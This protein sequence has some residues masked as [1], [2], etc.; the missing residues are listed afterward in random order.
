MMMASADHESIDVCRCWETGGAREVGKEA[1]QLWSWCYKATQTGMR[2]VN[3]HTK[4]TRLWGV[5]FAV[6]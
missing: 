3:T 4:N 5:V 1:P 6:V 2:K